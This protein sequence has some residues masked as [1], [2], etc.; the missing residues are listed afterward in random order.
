MAKLA[1]WQR[2][3]GMQQAFTI[4]N[5]RSFAVG[6]VFFD[7]NAKRYAVALF[8]TCNGDEEAENPDEDSPTF[9]RKNDVLGWLRS[10]KGLDVHFCEQQTR[11]F[12]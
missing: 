5:N 2:S 10:T 8:A 11:W 7:K 4:Y 6:E 9:C 12:K 1:W 3:G